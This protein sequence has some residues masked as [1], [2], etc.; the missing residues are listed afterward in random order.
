MNQTVTMLTMDLPPDLSE[1]LRLASRRRP[2]LTVRDITLE[3]LEEWLERRETM[4]DRRPP[5]SRLA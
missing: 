4:P 3:A 1:R 5:A 2:G